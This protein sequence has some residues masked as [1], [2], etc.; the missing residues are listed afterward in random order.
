M[1]RREALKKLS[2]GGA[3]A[4]GGSMILSSANVAYAM[5]GPLPTATIR[6]NSISGSTWTVELV[7]GPST[8]TETSRTWNYTIAS[9]SPTS[10]TVSSGPVSATNF[11]LF[12]SHPG[13]SGN[14]RAGDA[15]DFSVTVNFDCGPVTYGPT[16]L[17]G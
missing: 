6:T 3:I 11:Q 13:N 2:A 7:L 8:C 16:R 4:A 10:A 14:W 5:S 12:K 15:V 1:N 9:L 17:F